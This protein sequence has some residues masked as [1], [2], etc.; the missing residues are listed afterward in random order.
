MRTPNLGDRTYLVLAKP[1]LITKDILAVGG[2]EAAGRK[3][4]HNHPR[5]LRIFS[6]RSGTRPLVPG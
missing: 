5:P 4:P 6:V 3:S 2:R 1:N